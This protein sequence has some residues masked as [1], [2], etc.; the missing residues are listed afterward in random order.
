MT[1]IEGIKNK[2]QYSGCFVVSNVGHRGGL[3]V[4]WKNEGTA[5]ILGSN[6]RFIDLVVK[7]EGEE[8]YRMSCFYGFA[9]RQRRTESWEILRDLAGRSILPWVILGDFNEL[10]AHNEKRGRHAHPFTL[11]SNFRKAITDCGLKDLGFVGH[12]FTWE[13][14]CGTNRWVEERLDRALANE[15]WCRRFGQARLSHISRTVSDHNPILLEIFKF[16][17]KTYNRRFRFENAWISE[18]GCAAII[19]QSWEGSSGLEIQTRLGRCGKELEEWGREVRLKL[20]AEGRKIKSRINYLKGRRDCSS[21][22]A[23]QKEEERLNFL[24][25][26]EEIYWKQRAKIHWLKAGDANTKAFHRYANGWKQKNRIMSLIGDDGVDYKTKEGIEKVVFDYFSDLFTASPGAMEPVLQTV[27]KKVSEKHN[28]FLMSPVTPDEIR[29]AVFSMH[30]DKTAGADGFN[31]GFYQKYWSVVG[32]EVVHSCMKW[33]E[34]KHLPEGLN[35]T[36]IVLIPNKKKPNR[37]VDLRPISL[38]NVVYKV[39]SK[40]LANRL[41][42]VLPEVISETQSGFVAGRYIT[43]NIVVA[44]E[45]SHYLKRQ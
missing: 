42:C 21:I 14:W 36:T 33:V 38:C 31:P 34:L 15:A 16:V 17:P 27:R 41:K 28:E 8:P 23:L 12:P 24:L 25:V 39:M 2:L 5:T 13:K 30:P 20:H 35:V 40:V 6:H 32:E 37:M 11:I 45:I 19:K 7:L 26:Q 10:L 44:C 18:E 43:D 4:L 29:Q 22:T 3:A 1:A 9:D